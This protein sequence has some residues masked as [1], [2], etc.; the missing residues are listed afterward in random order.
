MKKIIIALLFLVSCADPPAEKKLAQTDSL[1]LLEMLKKASSPKKE[2]P[3][4]FPGWLTQMFNK[5][6][7]SPYLME[8]HQQV[9]E[10]AIVNDS[11]SYCILLISDGTCGTRHLVT[12]VNRKK[13]KDI[14]IA[15]ECT[16]D[17]SHGSYNWTEYSRKGIRD[18]EIT[19]YDE[20]ISDSLLDKDGWIKDGIED[21]IIDLNTRTDS[22]KRWLTINDAGDIIEKK[23]F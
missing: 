10:F 15:V 22:V 1:I 9:E 19:R 20:S 16:R 17:L 14:K 6:T 5:D 7:T 4:V 21:E 8:I 3:E 12:L 13:L 2:V 11:V 23:F 18:F